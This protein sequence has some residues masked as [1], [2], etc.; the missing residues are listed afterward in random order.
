MLDKIDTGEE[1]AIVV[2][3]EYQ[4]NSTVNG[5]HVYK[6]I[7][8]VKGEVLDT[9]MEPENPT[10]KYAVRKQWKRCGTFGESK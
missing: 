4:H 1:L 3:K 2:V 10:D 8:P 7:Y 9:R 5:F 6:E